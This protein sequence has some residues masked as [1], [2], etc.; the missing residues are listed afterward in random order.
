L[1]TGAESGWVAAVPVRRALVSRPESLIAGKYWEFPRFLDFGTNL[2][3][4][5]GRIFGHLHGNSCSP[6]TGDLLRRSRE[7]FDANR[8]LQRG[9]N[10][11][12]ISR[13][14]DM[15]EWPSDLKVRIQR[16]RETAF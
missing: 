13:R 5:Y 16:K 14:A 15:A 1:E 8:Q 9:W 10:S 2:E 12:I 11:S 4:N 3:P 7:I 6:I